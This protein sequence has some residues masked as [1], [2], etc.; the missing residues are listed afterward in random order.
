MLLKN[1][2]RMI[3]RI[4]MPKSKYPKGCSDLGRLYEHLGK[5]EKAKRRAEFLSSRKEGG[6]EKNAN[7]GKM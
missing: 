2:D 4:R 6:E 5:E 7:R 3:K 1:L